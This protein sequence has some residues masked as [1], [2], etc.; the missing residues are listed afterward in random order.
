MRYIDI[1]KKT[2]F[3]TATGLFISSLI[4]CAAVAKVST[5][6]AQRLGKDLT[7]LG[8]TKAGN[9]TGTIPPWTG[10]LK[11]PVEGYKNGDFHP[12]PYAADK[13]LLT[14]SA[15]NA[16]KYK[17]QIPAGN[18]ALLKAYP[19]YKMIVYP[20]RRSASRPQ[21]VYDAVLKNATTA[22]LSSTGSGIKNAIIGAP[23]PIPQKAEEVIWNHVLRYRAGP[24]G[25]YT[26]Y[27]GSVFPTPSGKYTFVSLKE[28]ILSLYGQPDADFNKLDNMNF[29][30]L[31]EVLAPAR[32]VGGK[33]LVHETLDQS[34]EP[35]RAW[36]YNPGQRR[37]RRAPTIA[38]DYPATGSDSL[39]TVD[40]ID[41]FNG[42]LDRYSWKLLGKREM[43]IPYNSYKLHSDSVKVKDIV[44]PKHINQDLAR[45]ELHRVWVVE[46]QL[47]DGKSHVY[48][49][50]R[51][52]IDEDNWQVA[53][54]DLYDRRG[55]LWRITEGHPINYYEVQAPNYTLEA[56]MDLQSGRYA[57]SGLDNELEPYDY[58]VKHP[59]SSFSPA[60]L[61]RRGR[62]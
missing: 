7:P 10:G 8:A 49:K 33:V 59:A 41:G 18:Y 5:K 46:A 4:S 48:G 23:F 15:A 17:D 29:M 28:D 51:F 31:Q 47:K 42:A 44:K 50:R 11:Q 58:Q 32:L 40:Q 24:N 60:A 26:R 34:I 9:K 54:V 12:D 21:W 6:E 56:T 36:S 61:R 53:V 22:E 37:V 52:Y 20:T 30:F 55:Q 43:Y 14:I 13:P 39:L 19:N 16:D 57:V 38:Y 3:V 2:I 1:K 27:T 25:S 62:R 35:R 45:Y